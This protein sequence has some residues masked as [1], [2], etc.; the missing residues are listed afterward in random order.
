MSPNPH[1]R[2]RV[3]E[4]PPD[5]AVTRLHQLVRQRDVLRASCRDPGERVAPGM[6]DREIEAWAEGALD[7][8][9]VNA[10]AAC[11]IAFWR[12]SVELKARI[13]LDALAAM[14]HI[15]SDVCR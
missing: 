14:A 11:L 15:F 5:R 4:T 13:G 6:P 3:I 8:A 9:F 7:L 1:S 12:A 2:L 10:G